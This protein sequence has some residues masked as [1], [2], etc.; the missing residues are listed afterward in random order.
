MLVW[1]GVRFVHRRPPVL[2]TPATERRWVTLPLYAKA[3]P[4]DRDPE[5]FFSL[6]DGFVWASWP[7]TG[8]SVELGHYT[9]VTEMMR[10]FLDQCELGERLLDRRTGSG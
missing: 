10:D 7:R 4:L 9:A 3:P 2:S 5:V 8:K 1:K 6:L